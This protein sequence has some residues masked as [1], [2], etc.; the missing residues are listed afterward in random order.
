MALGRWPWGETPVAFYVIAREGFRYTRECHFGMPGGRPSP[1]PCL[2]LPS[3]LSQLRLGVS[4]PRLLLPLVLAALVG[5]AEGGIYDRAAFITPSVTSSLPARSC[6][7]RSSVRSISSPSHP[8][9]PPS[10]SAGGEGYTHSPV[11]PTEG[12]GRSV[13][14]LAA[15]RLTHYISIAVVRHRF[16]PCCIFA[17]A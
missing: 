4:C 1:H 17:Q 13:H 14:Q 8:L 9:L 7:P 12:R 16:A 11:F 6:R 15:Y 3:G 5:L 2:I 10:A